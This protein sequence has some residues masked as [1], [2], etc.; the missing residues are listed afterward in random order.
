MIY[1]VDKHNKCWIGAQTTAQSLIL[2]PML[3]PHFRFGAH[4]TYSDIQRHGFTN[5][6]ILGA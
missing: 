3:S 1:K 2:I 4:I 5:L 6:L